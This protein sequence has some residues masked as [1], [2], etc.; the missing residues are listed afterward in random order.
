MFF[1]VRLQWA[2]TKDLRGTT[3]YVRNSS[4]VYIHMHLYLHAD[5]STKVVRKV[6]TKILEV[7]RLKHAEKESP[8]RFKSAIDGSPDISGFYWLGINQ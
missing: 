7:C 1:I 4:S 5:L 6:K 8:Q 2:K 3:R